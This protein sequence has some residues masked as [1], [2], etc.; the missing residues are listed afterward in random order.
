MLDVLKKKSRKSLTI[1]AIISI[2]IVI[3]LLALTDFAVFDV[4]TG[5]TE[6]DIT[7]Q[8][9]RYEGKYVTIDAQNFLT[10]YVEHTTTTTNT[11]TGSRSTSVDG[12]SYIVFNAVDDYENGFSVWYYYSIYMKKDL[13]TQIYGLIDDT[14]NYWADETNTVAPPAKLKVTG[15]WTKLEP[16]LERYYKETLEEMGIVESD[17]DVVY[18]YTIDTS[19]LGGQ[20]V[21]FFWACMV[22][23]LLLLIYFIINIAGIFSSKYAGNINKYLHNNPS[24]SLAA[25]E[26]DFSQAHLVGKKAWVGRKWTVYIEGPKADILSNKELVW[27]YYF[28]QTGKYSSSQL[29]VFNKDKKMFSINLSESEAHEALKYYAEEQPH[30]VV[31]YTKELETSFQKNFTEFLN[32]KYNPAIQAEEVDSY[33]RNDGNM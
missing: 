16:Q 30:M 13:K 2:A 23:A 21:G 5:P 15:T 27:G 6:L 7:A 29:R 18:L 4:I 19:K 9:E 33:F 12:N 17:Y 10:D 20:S 3:G 24:V 11:K 14:W 31:G 32:L 26:A 8:P 28:K 22:A 25:I 1:R